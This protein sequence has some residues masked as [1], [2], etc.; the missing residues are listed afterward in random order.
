MAQAMI[1]AAPE[2]TELPT[3]AAGE[4]AEGLQ[5]VQDFLFQFGYLPDPNRTSRLDE[6]TSCALKKYQEFHGIPV[7]GAFDE[8]TRSL[9]AQPRCGIP[10]LHDGARFATA[11]PWNRRNLTFAFDAGT[12]DILGNQEFTAVRNAIQTWA[13]VVRF[14]F[15]EVATTQNP[16]VMIGW[17]SANDPDLSMVGNAI[18]HADFPPGCGVINNTLPR[19]V[20]FD[21]TEHFWAIG[22]VAGRLDVQSVALHELGH[23]LGLQ[24]SVATSVMAPTFGTGRTRTTLTLDDIN[25]TRALYDWLGW[26][27]LGGALSSDIATGVNA[28]GRI[29]IFA[30]GTDN[31]AYH[32]WQITANSNNWTRW[33]PLGGALTTNIATARNADGRLEIFAR[34]TDSAAYHKWQI[35]ANSNN[36][37]RWEPLGG[38]LTSNIAT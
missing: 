11:C 20:H 16:D 31:A 25:S 15:R 8:S 29:E 14:N 24:H 12:S 17:R 28:D 3:V 13:G 10:D 18:A 6:T 27:S 1:A 35:T 9:M 37:T 5:V 36:W 30:R 2:I 26:E 38:G 4:Q 32:K 23:I 33:E 21:N 19:P 7:T 34:G 22:A